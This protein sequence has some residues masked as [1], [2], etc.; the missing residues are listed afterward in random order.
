MKKLFKNEQIILSGIFIIFS[1]SFLFTNLFKLPFFGTKVQITEIIFLLCI[2]LLPIKKIINIQI[3]ENKNIFILLILLISL[4]YFSSLIS[5]DSISILVT[6][7]RLYLLFLFFFFYYF[8]VKYLKNIFLDKIVI[9]IIYI[10]LFILLIGLVR[11]KLNL[12]TN[13]FTYFENYPYFGSVFRLQG[14]NTHPN[15]LANI[16]IIS[17]L[18]LFYSIKRDGKY[19]CH[20]IMAILLSSFFLFL[21]FSKSLNIYFISLFVIF[22][23]HIKIR[24]RYKKI[25][26]HNPS[27]HRS[28]V[29]TCLPR[30]FYDPIINK[31]F[32]EH[33]LL[34]L[35]I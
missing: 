27:L 5:H 13:I 7:G 16:L 20:K 33:Y 35:Y 4:Q 25:S 1:I 26:P 3:E 8:S 29:L 30:N 24:K 31:K 18:F 11:I 15:M 14:F 34:L 17:N 9:F 6:S 23:N 2:P 10:V 32:R 22:L 28:D 12:N 21:T 19:N